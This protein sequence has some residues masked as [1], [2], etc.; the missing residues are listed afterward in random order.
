[1]AQGNIVFSG[2]Q[3]SSLEELAGGV[4]PQVNLFTDAAGAVR[5]RPGI[6]TW[7]DFPEETPNGYAVVQMGLLGQNLVYVTEDRKIFALTAP[8]FVTDISTGGVTTELDGTLRPV[9]ASTRTRLIIAG[10]GAPQKWEGAGDTA[11]LGG[12][13]P[14]FSHV[15]TIAQRVV[16]NDSGV[17]GILYWSDLGD[18]GHE[19]WLTGLNFAEAETKPDPVIGLYE[20]ANEL[21][22]LG[23]QT[24]QMLSPDPSIVFSPARTMQFGAVSGHGF[25]GVDEQFFTLDVRRRVMQSNGRSYAAVSSPS[26]AKQIDEMET[27]SDVWGFRSQ[28][29]GYDPAV[30]RFPTSGKTFVYDVPS[31]A[32]SEWRGFST[33]T[34]TWADYAPTSHLFWP[35]RNIHLVGL[36][37]GRIARLDPDA[38]S[39][40]GDPIVCE[41][42][43]PFTDHGVMEPKHCR[44]V[45]FTLR[46]GPSLGTAKVY[47]SYRDDLGPFCAPF[48]RELGTNSDHHIELFSLGTYRSRQWRIMSTDAK[49]SIANVKETFTI[50]RGA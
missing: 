9:M 14:N 15:A 30:F 22:A 36:S 38:A 16:G 39:D 35:E 6:S 41:T 3:S 43:S 19:T 31:K 5:P 12:S 42:T 48:I 10:G 2:G 46:R 29:H 18:T 45:I 11:R 40:L 27:V 4:P 50:T 21:V 44:T 26:V 37:N 47:I 28:F 34:G 49:L 13:P 25:V 23:T 8:G 7:E 1:M 33:V 17:S 24:V 20:S 32:W